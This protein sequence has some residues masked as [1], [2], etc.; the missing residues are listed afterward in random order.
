M[1][2]RFTKEQAEKLT[3]IKNRVKLRPTKSEIVQR[4]ELE[5]LQERVKKASPPPVT[6]I[7]KRSKYGNKKTTVGGKTFDSQKEALRYVQLKEMENRGEIKD[8]QLQI[9]FPIHY[10]GVKICSYIADFTYLN[11]K[12]VFCCEDVKGF[13]TAI[14][15][16][17]KK[18]MAAFYRIE[19]TET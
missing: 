18:M 16:L 8:L 1:G 2:A 14:Y 11:S 17:K 19:I 15:K 4:L 12:G 5:K 6:P 13:K 7:K 3:I 10:S 9:K